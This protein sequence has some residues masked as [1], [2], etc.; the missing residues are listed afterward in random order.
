MGERGSL[1][2]SGS[3]LMRTSCTNRKLTMEN[4]YLK[5][6]RFNDSLKNVAIWGYWTDTEMYGRD[7]PR[8][9]APF[10]E[11]LSGKSDYSINL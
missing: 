4:R 11:A 9:N 8:E 7:T 10:F 5:N 1:V 3:M 6:R 2:T